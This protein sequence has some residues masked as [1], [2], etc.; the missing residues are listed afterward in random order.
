MIRM[1][2]PNSYNLQ[3]IG[4]CRHVRGQEVFGVQ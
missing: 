1:G 4:L 2:M 3:L